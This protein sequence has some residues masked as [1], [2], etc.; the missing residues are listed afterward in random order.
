ML[1]RHS[2]YYL[3]ASGVPGIINFLAIYFYT[4]LLT[5]EEYGKYALVVAG[6]GLFNVVFF[7]WYRLALLRFFPAYERDPRPL[8]STLLA[9]FLIALLL[10]GCTGLAVATLWPSPTLRPLIF[11]GITLLWTTAWFELNLEL[12][13]VQLMPKRYG[14]MAA[15]KSVSAL[16]I[17][18]SLTLI[19]PDAY[20]PLLGLLLG[21]LFAG[22]YGLKNPIWRVQPKLEREKISELF[23]Y[24]APLTATFAL[25]YIVSAS[26][27]FIL[28]SV[29]GE[30]E[31]GL[32]SA[33]YDLANQ[34]LTLMMTIV[35][36][37]AYPLVVRA[38]EAGGKDAANAQLS[39]NA[40]LLLAV[41]LPSATGL[42]VL[43]PNIASVVLGDSFSATTAL[44]L[45][46]VAIGSLL[47]GVRAYFFDL[48][49]Q[50]GRWTQGQ[51]LVMSVAAIT[52]VLLN[53]LW[54]PRYGIAGSA[55]AT[56][57]AY[58]VALVVSIVL[59]RRIFQM[60]FPWRDSLKLLAATSI[61]GIALIPTR[62]SI[63]LMT[64][65]SQILLGAT[66][67]LL[68]LLVLNVASVRAYIS[69]LWEQRP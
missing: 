61:M 37:A 10:T 46:I 60:T 31:A 25:S 50:L 18:T 58:G 59:G 55:W 9:S 51:I 52:N 43:S 49:F 24:G 54:I 69:S 63:G 8:I 53:F 28:A 34:S 36:L 23:R 47:A 12:S 29:L 17:G 66:I 30:T 68:M 2:A 40:V 3:L 5:P 1:L 14:G 22:A 7:Q 41:A 13:R 27:R 38:L 44:L 15:F 62:E 39:K 4:R 57:S 56:V 35:N 32:Y 16:A 20:G 33:P 42:A 67:Y 11:L 45:P 26:D 64:L 21:L 65:M 48:A 19:G 6:V